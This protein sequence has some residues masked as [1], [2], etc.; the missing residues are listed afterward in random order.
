MKILY[1]HQIFEHQRV[2]GVSR[3]FAEIIRHLPDDVEADVSVLYSFNEYLK[4]LDIPFV[5]KDQLINYI[6]FFPNLNFR[7]KKRLY[8]YLEKK[9]PTRYP[10][11]FRLNKEE[12][13]ERLKMQDFD[14]FHPTLYDDYFLDYIGNKPYVLTVH[15][16]IIELYPEFI[17]TPNFIK[18]KRKLVDNAAH[19]IAVSENTK[20]DIVNIFGT[21]PDKISVIYHASSLKVNDNPMP[22]ENLPK[23]YLLYVGDRRLGYKNFAFFVSSIVP[24]LQNDK[25][26][27]VV[28]TGGDF[29]SEE[30]D[31]FKNLGISDRMHIRFVDDGNMSQ[32]YYSALLFVYP[33]YY[34]GFGIPILEAFQAGCPVLMAKSSCFPE[35]AADAGTY[36][37]YKSPQSLRDAIYSLTDNEDYRNEMIKKGRNRLALFSWEISAKQ[38]V[39]IYNKVL[40]K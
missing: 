14:V 23:K 18:R 24:I 15:D 36:F 38:T 1:D 35:V 19:V 11:F 34:E 21:S 9:Y 27:H 39:E 13:I 40:S 20:R 37:E 32:L 25:N 26:L 2:G 17:N 4:N 10:D 8:Q 30:K 31:F 22:L 16:M 6:Y 3:Y 33:S 5:W 29:T 28:C 7:G 12:T